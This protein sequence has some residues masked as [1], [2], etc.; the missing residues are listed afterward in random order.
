M[1]PARRGRKP[2]ARTH[3]CAIAGPSCRP[4][5]RIL[6][7][8]HARK[9]VVAR[10][11]NPLG[12]ALL[13]AQQGSLQRT[14]TSPALSRHVVGAAPISLIH[15]G[16]AQD[17]QCRERVFGLAFQLDHC[18]HTCHAGMMGKM[19]ADRSL[20]S[21]PR[22]FYGWFVVAGAFA[23]TFVGFGS[24]Y[25]F[26][27]FIASLQR[28]FAASRGSVS[29][30]FSVAGF[31]YFALGLVSGPLAD[32]FGARLLAVIGIDPDR[33]R[34]C[35]R[36]RGAQPAGSLRGLRPRRRAWHRFLLCSDP[37][38]RP[39][40][41]RQTPRSC[42]RSRRERDR[43]RHAGHAARRRNVDRRHGMAWGLS[44]ARLFCGDR[45]RRNGPVGRGRS[46]PPRH[47]DRRR[48]AASRRATGTVR[49]DRRARRATI[50]AVCRA[51]RREPPWLVRGVRAVRSPRPLRY[52][53]RHPAIFGRSPDG[54]DRHRQH[55][56]PLLSR[57]SR[58]SAG[59]R[60]FLSW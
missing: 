3:R 5:S 9:R 57:R 16:W 4:S 22:V 36:K 51:L 30:V 54:R 55:Q 53:P 32:R 28:D 46:A 19:A 43:C 38:C 21:R 56:R 2:C 49:D 8:C 35:F 7:I 50:A 45:G 11:A 60:G 40:M 31:L 25:T 18:L 13:K 48:S 12:C 26:S 59:A 44:R 33:R 27:A 23:V 39:A 34:P 37:G 52:G 10:S 15:T 1:S 58:R 17:N 24:A 29:L 41:V 14:A 47:G 42:I 6:P 20:Q